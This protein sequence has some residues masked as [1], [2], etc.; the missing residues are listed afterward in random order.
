MDDGYSGTNF[1]RLNWQ[2]LMALVDEDKVGMV[3][4]KDMSRLDR[5]Y[6]KVGYT[7]VALPGADIQFIAINNA[8]QQGSDFIPFLNIINE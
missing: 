5:D 1:D 7:E 4:V 3:I 8:N 6:L 2:H